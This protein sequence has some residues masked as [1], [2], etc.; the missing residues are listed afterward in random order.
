[1]GKMRMYVCMYVYAHIHIHIYI[2]VP[3]GWD[4]TSKAICMALRETEAR[5]LDGT[6]AE[7]EARRAQ[8]MARN[9]IVLSAR[10]HVGK[11]NRRSRKEVGE[12]GA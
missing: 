7:A 6:K 4:S 5:M 2:Y 9:C 10:K 12:R 3:P 11:V 1:M 8:T